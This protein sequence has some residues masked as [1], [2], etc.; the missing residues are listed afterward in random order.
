MYLNLPQIWVISDVINLYH[1]ELFPKIMD[2]PVNPTQPA[3]Q[4][5]PG[6]SHRKH[7][8]HLGF[9]PNTLLY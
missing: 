7:Q 4:L 1:T 2:F 8:K 9:F 3:H 5:F 6:G